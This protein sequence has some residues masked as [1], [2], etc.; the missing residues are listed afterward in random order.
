[1][2]LGSD[3]QNGIG[4]FLEA[5]RRLTVAAEPKNENPLRAKRPS[6]S[7]TLLDSI[8]SDTICPMAS[9]DD[10]VT[11]KRQSPKGVGFND[12]CKVSEWYFGKPRQSGTSHRIY[13]TPW[14]GDPR[15]KIQ[16]DRGKAKPY[17]VRQVLLAIDRLEQIDG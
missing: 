8:D 9:V 17:P 12:L 1:M 14:P 4:E 6:S 16:K 3:K 2:V 15:V 13:K 7:A 5:S 11:L 10:I